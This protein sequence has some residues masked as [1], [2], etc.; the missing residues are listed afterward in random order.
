MDDE[1]TNTPKH[2]RKNRKSL[3]Q[4]NRP[5]D[6]SW[7]QHPIGYGE[8]SCWTYE[9]GQI[10]YSVFLIF[11]AGLVSHTLRYSRQDVENFSTPE[12]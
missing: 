10:D 3:H 2:I 4:Y 8:S 11:D 6:N 5:D 7:S 12:L 1:S 9:M